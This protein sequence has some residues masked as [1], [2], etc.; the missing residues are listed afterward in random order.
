M[1]IWGFPPEFRG[2]FV[3]VIPCEDGLLVCLWE[4]KWSPHPIPLPSWDCP[5]E[6]Y[7]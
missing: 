5:P 4:R 6:A 1:G 2:R 3:E 7:F